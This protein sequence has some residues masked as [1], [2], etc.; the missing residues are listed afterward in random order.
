VQEQKE[1]YAAYRR[2]VFGDTSDIFDRRLRASDASGA[3]S[4]RTAVSATVPS[5]VGPTPFASMS[6]A[7]AVAMAAAMNRSQTGTS[8]FS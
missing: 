1:N 5:T 2:T 8:A 3:S 6:N 4:G 7:A